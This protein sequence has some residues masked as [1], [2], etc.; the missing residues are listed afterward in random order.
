MGRIWVYWEGQSFKDAVGT[1]LGEL[2]VVVT[3]EGILNHWTKGNVGDTRV[4]V[5]VE[6]KDVGWKFLDHEKKN[7]DTWKCLEDKQRYMMK[8]FVS[9]PERTPVACFHEVFKQQKGLSLALGTV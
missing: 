3:A 4:H 7:L 5:L 6:E 8:Y 1:G 9:P 2:K